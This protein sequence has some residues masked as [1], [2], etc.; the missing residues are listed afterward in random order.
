MLGF[1]TQDQTRIATATSEIAR[2]AFIYAGKGT[3]EFAVAGKRPQQIF[4]IRIRDDGPGIKDLSTLM[5]QHYTS[6]TGLG[7]GIIGASRLME[8]FDIDSTLNKGT[9]VLLG[10]PIPYR[11]NAT[12]GLDIQQI[13][14]ELA[15]LAAQSALDEVQ[16]Q[17][18]ELLT[19]M[20][21]LVKLNGELKDT[22]RG[23][24]ALYAELEDRAEQ[25]KRALEVKSQFFSYLGHEMRT[26]VSS[27]R[28]M[29]GILLDR[30]DGELT[31]EQDKQVNYIYKAA[32]DLMEIIN[33]LLDLS[34][35]EAKK[36][37]ISPNQFKVSELFGSLR[38]IMKPL[39]IK[40]AV[41][42]YFEEP[43]DIPTLYNDETKVAQIL[44]N[45]ISNALKFTE[46]GEVRV[47]ARM[48]DDVVEFSVSDTGIG[49]APQDQEHIFEEFYQIDSNLQKEV[50][51]TGLGLALSKKLALAL[52]GD[53]SLESELG[54]GSTFAVMIPLIHIEERQ[55]SNLVTQKILDQ[56][57]YPVLVVEDDPSD[58]ALF[59]KHL[60][61]SCF[62]VITAS[63]LKEA[64]NAL[65]MV[66]PLA[67]ILDILLLGED[68]W[69]LLTEMK[70]DDSTRDI[71]VLITTIIDDQQEKAL[72]LGADEYF[73]K[74]VNHQWLLEKLLALIA[75]EKI[76][77]IDDQPID[78][79]A[80]K[81][82]LIETGCTIIEAE[83]GAEGIRK[84]KEEHPQVIFLDLVMPDMNGFEV[85]DHLNAD[86]STQEIPVIIYTNK[87]LKV[88]ERHQLLNGSQSILSKGTISRDEI[89]MYLNEAIH[90]VRARKDL[91]EDK[92]IRNS[93]S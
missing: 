75:L 47:S 67:V 10:K 91:G 82:K 73:V 93:L 19:I 77:I 45:L 7:L 35:V 55:P 48:I 20:Q 44:R 78:R 80:L 39:N 56:V 37:L 66:R 76:L 21:D 13:T 74:P 92:I 12:N 11:T 30:L 51:G 22:N 2:N 27:I 41:K 36:F 62:Q 72:E 42:L 69:S 65:K 15:K 85:L 18:Q 5:E 43:K 6:K 38:G 87:E 50:K 54:V 59:E 14:N 49:I 61:D 26:P 83:N 4:L 16:I 71:P 90:K 68:G 58:L 63:T 31:V 34:R 46:H 79:Y 70:R 28:S 24:M 81:R 9:T 33:D 84:A 3:A 53:L 23:V 1:N 29:S 64:H 40:P 57:K 32:S 89:I 52:N 17:N 86:L 25:L 88:E 8:Y 60:E